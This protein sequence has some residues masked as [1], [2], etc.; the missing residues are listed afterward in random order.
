MWL[1]SGNTAP[2]HKTINEFRRDKLGAVIEKMF[3]QFVEIL[4]ELGEVSFE[5]VFPD[6]TKIEASENRYTF[7]A[8]VPRVGRNA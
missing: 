8:T 6:G 3:Y 7:P 5:N 1:L 4:Y 2:S